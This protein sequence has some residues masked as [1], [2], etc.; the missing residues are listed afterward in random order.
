VKQASAKRRTKG[1]DWKY[2][3]CGC[4]GHT[5][6]LFGVHFSLYDTLKGPVYLAVGQHHAHLYGTR[7]DSHKKAM[8]RLREILTEKLTQVRK[9]ARQVRKWLQDG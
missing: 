1:L 3:E 7:Y 2:C 8:K 4:H 9:D 5:V 6:D